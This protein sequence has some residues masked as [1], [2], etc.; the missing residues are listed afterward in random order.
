MNSASLKD[1]RFRSGLPRTAI[2]LVLC[3]IF[4]WAG[5]EKIAHPAAFFSALLDY[6][7]PF[8]DQFVRVVAVSLPWLEVFCGIA[9]LLNAWAETV[10]PLV[11]VLCLIFVLMLG[12]ALLRGID[13]ANCGCFGPLANTW[14]DRPAVAFVRA[15]ALFAGSLFLLS[16][17][18]Q[19]PPQTA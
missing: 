5:A 19:T 9:L 7:V 1:T 2:R 16:P 11:S 3:I 6:E 12:Q 18:S 13:L 10:R 8:P 17:G 4:I 15:V 14:I